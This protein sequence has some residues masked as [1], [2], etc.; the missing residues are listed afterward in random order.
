M[1]ALDE[2]QNIGFN[3]EKDKRNPKNRKEKQ[4]CYRNGKDIKPNCYEEQDTH[5]EPLKKV[6]I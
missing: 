4:L 3:T 6:L 1:S 2:P 5:T